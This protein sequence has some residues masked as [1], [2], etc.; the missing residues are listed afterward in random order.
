MKM[1]P[2]QAKIDAGEYPELKATLAFIADE[3]DRADRMFCD[4]SALYAKN[5]TLRENENENE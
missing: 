3:A 1:D 2:I 4:L 5:C